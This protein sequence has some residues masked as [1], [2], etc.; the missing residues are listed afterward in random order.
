MSRSNPPGRRVLVVQDE[1]FTAFSIANVVLELGHIV[2][3]PAF[4]WDEARRLAATCKMDIAL[5]DAKLQ[6]RFAGEIADI[7]VCRKIPFAFV[8]GYE[9][10]P[11]PGY[12]YVPL[13]V[14]PFVPSALQRAIDVLLEPCEPFAVAVRT[15]IVANRGGEV[16]R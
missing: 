3:G 15:K 6:G 9:E 11:F 13:V 1:P 16:L 2:V 4:S 7:C 14:K 8:T 5:L 10:I 12:R